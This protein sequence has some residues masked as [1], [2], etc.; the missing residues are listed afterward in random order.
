MFKPNVI[1]EVDYRPLNS[2][3]NMFNVHMQELLTKIKS[4]RK[5]VLC[6]D[7]YNKSYWTIVVMDLHR[8]I[9]I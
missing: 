9:L 3:I 7:D 4:E 1:I 5:D 6:L 2:D 8:N